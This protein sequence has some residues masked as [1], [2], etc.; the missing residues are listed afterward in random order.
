[1]AYQKQKYIYLDIA[2]QQ[3]E[4]KEERKKLSKE[5]TFLEAEIKKVERESRPNKISNIFVWESKCLSTSPQT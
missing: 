2:R 4:Y 1:M 3:T 5:H